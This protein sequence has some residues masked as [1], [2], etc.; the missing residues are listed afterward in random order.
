MDIKLSL[1]NEI[2]LPGEALLRLMAEL[3][4]RL[5]SH[6][7]DVI[8]NSNVFLYRKPKCKEVIAMLM[9]ECECDGCAEIKDEIKT[10]ARQGEVTE[11]RVEKILEI[12]N[13]KHG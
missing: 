13:K 12:I 11:E 7:Y 1:S 3:S 2:E 10:M 8:S 6:A 4:K 9:P 5:G